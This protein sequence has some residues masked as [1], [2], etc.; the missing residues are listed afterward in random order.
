MAVVSENL[1]L[2]SSGSRPAAQQEGL[3]VALCRLMRMRYCIVRALYQKPLAESPREAEKLE[4]MKTRLRK[5]GRTRDVTRL[6]ALLS[7]LFLVGV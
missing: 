5:Q 2:V 6:C 1:S 3:L 7:K 4:M